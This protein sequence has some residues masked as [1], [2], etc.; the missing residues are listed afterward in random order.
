[1]KP[2]PERGSSALAFVLLMFSLGMV[3]LNGLQQ[4][5]NLQQSVVAGEVN[6]LQQYAQALSAQS[7]GSQQRWEPLTQWQ[8]KM[9][10]GLWRACVLV[11]ETGEGIMA[12]QKVSEQGNVPITL[13]HWGNIEDTRWVVAP[14]GWLDFCPLSE[15]ALCLLPE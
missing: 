15:V 13:W 2:H 7:W 3:M 14:H 4:Q 9:Q 11:L 1:M 5:L 8:C 10:G 6:Y 12:A